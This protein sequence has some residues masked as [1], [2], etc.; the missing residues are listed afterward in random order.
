MR[1]SFA[2]FLTFSIAAYG[3][4]VGTAACATDDSIAPTTLQ[5]EPQTLFSPQQLDNLVASVALYPDPL[6]A[7]VVVAATFPEQIDEAARFL[8]AGANPNA[9]DAQPWDVSVKAVAHYPTVLYMMADNL[10]WTTSLGQAYVYQSTAVLAAVQRLRV[11]ARSRGHLVTTPQMEVVV[12]NGSIALWPLHPPTLYVPVYDPALVFYRYPGYW[13]GPGIS[14]SIGFAV[15]AWLIYDFDWHR[16]H[17][18]YHGW[19]PKGG[20]VHRYRRHVHITNVYVHNRPTHVRGNRRVVH[21]RVN[22]HTLQRY[23]AVHRHVHYDDVY[24]RWRRVDR[25]DVRRERGVPDARR[26]VR[27]KVIRRNFD[28]DDPRLETNRG[29]LV[30][31]RPGRRRPSRRDVRPAPERRQPT[32]QRDVRP[33][34]RRRQTMPRVV[35]PPGRQPRRH[36]QRGENPVFRGSR[37]GIDPRAARQRGRA[38][39]RQ[40]Q[41]PRPAVRSRGQRRQVP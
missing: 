10:D 37:R 6:L 25:R 9:I 31:R 4:L 27:N 40:M 11:R 34:P 1:K 36:I 23:N 7:Q 8:R 17:V 39:W 33:A 13:G 15:G 24:R 5:A 18:Y 38:S 20:W 19:A 3:L 2:I 12:E 21:R 41:R 14:F 29:R 32:P 35:R 30:E 28:P 26:D 16:R 22:Y